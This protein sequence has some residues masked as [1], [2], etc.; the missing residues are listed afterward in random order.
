MAYGSPISRRDN[1]KIRAAR[2]CPV[3]KSIN[4][5]IAKTN[6]S[7][8]AVVLI[9][10]IIHSLKIDEPFYGVPTL[11]ILRV[12][13]EFVLRDVANS[14]QKI[15]NLESEV[16]RLINKLHRLQRAGAIAELDKYMVIFVA[17][18]NYAKTDS[19]T[20]NAD[21]FAAAMELAER[22]LSE[23]EKLISVRLVV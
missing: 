15:T 4:A 1:A 16:A 7:K 14:N 11:E 17:N 12:F 21:S 20:V 10:G 23:N 9:D 18:N 13:E 2:K 8:G 19:F 5:A 6:Y 22:E 3:I